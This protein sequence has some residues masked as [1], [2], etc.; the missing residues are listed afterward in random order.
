MVHSV[1][2]FLFELVC[3]IAMF[4]VY[5]LLLLLLLFSPIPFLALL[6]FLLVLANIQDEL[7]FT[8][9][10][11][12]PSPLSVPT[13]PTEEAQHAYRH[14][15]T[16]EHIQATYKEA[17]FVLLSYPF[18]FFTRTAPSFPFFASHLQC[19]LPHV[20]FPSIPC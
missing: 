20:P 3:P 4:L 12:V 16:R 1:R 2:G 14:T 5:F 19:I 15:S 9:N 6:H 11:F 10:I 7:G 8:P 13:I 18:F 17:P